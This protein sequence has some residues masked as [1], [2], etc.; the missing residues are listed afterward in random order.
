MTLGPAQFLSFSCCISSISLLAMTYFTVRE[1][2]RTR[3]LSILF[4]AAFMTILAVAL[5][6]QALTLRWR[7]WFPGAEGTRSL[8]GGVMAATS[9][10]MS[11]LI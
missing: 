1:Y 2:R 6:A 3:K 9:S 4:V 7:P 5:I 10:I 11:Q 8:T